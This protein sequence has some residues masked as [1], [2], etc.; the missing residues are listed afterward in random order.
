MTVGFDASQL[1][2]L[3]ADLGEA[4]PKAK[5]ASS[6]DM[7]KIAAQLRDDAK[8]DAPVDTG[9]TR[10][11]IRVH[12]REGYRE[13]VA[14]SRAAFFQEFGTSS[15]PPQPF[16]WPNADKAAERLMEAMEQIADPF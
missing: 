15:H 1:A 4:G 5:R 10:D 13:V 6:R 16:M 2:D 12:G 11:S 8:A 7:T 9:E 14:T 3:A